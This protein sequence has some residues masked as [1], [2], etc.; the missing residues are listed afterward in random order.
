MFFSCTKAEYVKES[1]PF[2]VM[3]CDRCLLDLPGIFSYW[4]YLISLISFSFVA[5]FFLFSFHS[6]FFFY[7]LGRKPKLHFSSD[8]S[9]SCS[10]NGF[11]FFLFQ[12]FSISTFKFYFCISIRSCNTC[13][14]L[15]IQNCNFYFP[16]ALI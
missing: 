1:W 9:F 8:A 3:F 12:L 2:Q 14:C 4:I 7:P 5:I 16:L 11:I 6:L 10:G 15:N 13:F